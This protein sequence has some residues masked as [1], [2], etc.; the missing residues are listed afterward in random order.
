MKK[1]IIPETS[2]LF[3]LITIQNNI[4]MEYISLIQLYCNRPYFTKKFISMSYHDDN[5]NILKY[6]KSLFSIEIE[7]DPDITFEKFSEIIKENLLNGFA[8][9]LYVD[10]G[11]LNEYV[12]NKNCFPVGSP[13]MMMIIKE[14]KNTYRCKD[15]FNSKEY[16]ERD[17]SLKRIFDAYTSRALMW[18]GINET[19]TIRFYKEKKNDIYI[20]SSFKKNLIRKFSLE[21]KKYNIGGISSGIATGIDVY[22]FFEEYMETF[23]EG[24]TEYDKKII[25]TIILHKKMIVESLKFLLP[26]C[27]TIDQ[28]QEH[29]STLQ[30]EA[31]FLL[32]CS[33]QKNFNEKKILSVIER[34][35]EYKKNETRIFSEIILKLEL[36]Y[37]MTKIVNLKEEVIIVNNEICSKNSNVLQNRTDLKIDKIIIKEKCEF[38]SIETDILCIEK[39]AELKVGKI[40]V[41]DKIICNGTLRAEELYCYTKIPENDHFFIKKSIYIP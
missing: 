39:D 2:H 34:I 38:N 12:F 35:K 27:K 5:L 24:E 33:I 10:R 19:R 8:A 18:I 11:Y 21:I 25:S 29:I 40:L 32:K 16:E 26:S 31:I 37:E 13:H 20:E 14:D 22:D 23:L 36:E 3:S 15:F 9:V 41:R 1:T 4:I 7:T 17:I 30:T 28:L 6:S